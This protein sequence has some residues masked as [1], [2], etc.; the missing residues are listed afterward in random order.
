[1][2]EL[3]KADKDSDTVKE[4]RSIFLEA[5]PREERPPFLFLLHRAKSDIVDFCGIFDGDKLVGFTYVVKNNGLVYLFF[6]AIKRESRGCGYGKEVM[7]LLIEKYRG[8]RFFLAR[9][10]LDES[11]ENYQQRVTRRKFYEDCGL[12]DMPYRIREASVTYDVMG[13]GG[14]IDP[15]EYKEMINRY[16]GFLRHFVRM[17]FSQN[18]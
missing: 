4:I 6:L 14:V 13:I 5:F 18:H 2:I 11:A 8:C 1:M 10:Q 17:E 9:E 16:L 15:E 3:R 12:K 7:R